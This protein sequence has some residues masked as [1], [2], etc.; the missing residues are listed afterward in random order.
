MNINNS[1]G[2]L[3]D[4][5]V[6]IK[7]C[8]VIK[9]NI[10]ISIMKIDY[11]SKTAVPRAKLKI[12]NLI[13]ENLKVRNISKNNSNFI[14]YSFTGDSDYDTTSNMKVEKPNIISINNVSYLNDDN[15][16]GN[17]IFIKD[18]FDKD[19]Y[20]NEVIPNITLSNIFFSSD[21]INNQLI[22]NDKDID[23][24]TATE[25]NVQLDTTKNL[26][27]NSSLTLDNVHLSLY[28][29]S[30]N[31]KLTI[32]NSVIY[33]YSIDDKITN[34]NRVTFLNSE[35][36]VFPYNIQNEGYQI[37]CG[38]YI[39]TVFNDYTVYISSTGASKIANARLSD[40]AILIGTNKDNLNSL[41]ITVNPKNNILELNKS[42]IQIA[43]IKS[44]TLIKLPSVSKYTE[45]SLI[46]ST[47]KYVNIMIPSCKMNSTPS[48]V[49]NKTFRLNFTFI[50][51]SIGWIGEAIAYG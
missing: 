28:H 30:D 26:C 16:L 27:E 38:K 17:I 10:N 18:S 21:Y 35:V 6:I 50:N 19:I 42:R 22:F 44:S 24:F 40:N 3:F 48:Y 32:S 49:A 12:P 8:E 46:F 7:D 51:N 34:S 13:V 14:V 15:T 4:G 5:T 47:S 11:I 20:N 29:G 1:Y 9:D 23:I 41:P 25:N 2:Y 45:I 36:K 37:P 43:D 39:N 33:G 31:T